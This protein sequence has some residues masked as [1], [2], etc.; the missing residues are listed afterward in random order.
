MITTINLVSIHHL[1]ELPK[2][3]TNQ[4]NKKNTFF[5]LVMRTFRIYSL[6][7]FQLYHTAVY[8]ELITVD[9]KKGNLREI[10][11][12]VDDP[13]THSSHSHSFHCPFTVWLCSLH[14]QGQLYA[15]LVWVQSFVINS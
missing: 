7:N 15:F 3:P 6:G 1:I 13:A 8:T 5:F 12:E 4:P 14:V 10:N 2:E 11:P 9:V